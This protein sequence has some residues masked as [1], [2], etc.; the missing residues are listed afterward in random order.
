MINKLETF[1]ANLEAENKAE[2]L[3]FTKQID[4]LKMVITAQVEDL[5]IKEV[6]IMNLQDHDIELQE[7]VRKFEVQKEIH[8]KNLSGQINFFRS[9]NEK[10]ESDFKQIIQFIN[11]RTSN[12]MAFDDN[13]NCNDNSNKKMRTN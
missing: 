5:K 6:K 7:S 4:D 3:K 13:E 10:S 8:I 1:I 11:K 2:E 9:K 12:D